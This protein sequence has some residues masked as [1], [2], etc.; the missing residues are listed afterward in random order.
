MAQPSGIAIMRRGRIDPLRP[1]HRRLHHARVDDRA[2]P[3]DRSWPPGW[4]SISAIAARPGGRLPGRCGSDTGWSRPAPGPAASHAARRQPVGQGLLQL[5]VGQSMPL[6]Q[7]QRPHHQ[8]RRVAGPA[9]GRSPQARQDARH[10]SPVRQAAIRS[11]RPAQDAAR[12][13]HRNLRQTAL[14]HRLAHDTPSPPTLRAASESHIHS[15]SQRSRLAFGGVQKLWPCLPDRS[16]SRAVGIRQMD[17]KSSAFGGVRSPCLKAGLDLA[18]F[19]RRGPPRPARRQTPSRPA[20]RRGC[21]RSAWPRTARR[22]PLRPGPP[23]R[24]PPRPSTASRRPPRC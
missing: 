18:C 17:S 23:C 12:S 4:R 6:R 11:S 15:V 8:R 20:S 5:G 19:L 10:R 9:R 24:T 14:T 13:A 21:A 16:H 7:Q 1:M 2:G 22:R 3:Q